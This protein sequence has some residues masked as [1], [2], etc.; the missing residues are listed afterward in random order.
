[1]RAV[2]PDLLWIGNARDGRN[3]EAVL[4]LGIEAVIDL[5]VEEPP[6]LFPRETAY[7]RFPLIDG[8]GNRPA[9]IQAAIDTTIGFIRGNVP[10]L[11]TCNGGMSRSPAIVAA[12][13]VTIEKIAAETALERVARS[14]PHDVSVSF[15]AEVKKQSGSAR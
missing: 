7:C 1:M 6:M 2:I 8:E 10:T 11:V 9:M 15:W 5:A 3:V 12:A 4:R 14:G 13:L